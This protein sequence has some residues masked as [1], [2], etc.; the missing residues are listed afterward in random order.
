MFPFVKELAVITQQLA[1]K[2]REMDR[3]A[4]STKDAEQL[5]KSLEE[6]EQLRQATVSSL[7]T[8]LHQ[9]GL[10]FLFAFDSD[11]YVVHNVWRRWRTA[12]GC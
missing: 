5:R 1:E 11:I 12:H 3:V 2:Q 10:L 9:V 4:E 7:Q 6:S 8:S